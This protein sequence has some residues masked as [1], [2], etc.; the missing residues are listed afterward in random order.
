MSFASLIKWLNPDTLNLVGQ[1]WNLWGRFFSPQG[2]YEVLEYESCLELLDINGKQAVF[3]K[4][5][6]VR[7]LQDNVVAYQDQ[8]WGD[9]QIFAEYECSP[10]V[11]VD[12]Y[13][14]G[15]RWRVLI[16][17]RQ[18]YNRGDTEEFHIKRTIRDGFPGKTENFQNRLD[19]HTRLAYFSVIFPKGRLPKQVIFL[20]NNKGRLLRPQA[21]QV[22]TLPD[23]RQ[24]VGWKVRYADLYEIYSIRWEW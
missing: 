3:T 6:K 4:R 10:G 5:Q 14:E 15:N 22:Q 19:H 21:E 16:S 17:L 13:Q 8:A 23:G 24:Q 18:T 1:L 12:R 7:F 2:L 11:A 20:E 9:G